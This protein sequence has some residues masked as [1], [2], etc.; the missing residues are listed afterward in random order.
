[1]NE[2]E[3]R[4]T[5]RRGKGKQEHQSTYLHFFLNRTIFLDE[6]LQFVNAGSGRLTQLMQV[7]FRLF[8]RLQF[9]FQTSVFGRKS[10]VLYLQ[11]IG[12]EAQAINET[13][14]R[15]KSSQKATLHNDHGSRDEGKGKAKHDER[16]RV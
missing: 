4:T 6:I 8:E 12:L 15:R 11:T 13:T 16:T 2:G 3:I 14:E 9:P 7:E 5:K 1:M 10:I